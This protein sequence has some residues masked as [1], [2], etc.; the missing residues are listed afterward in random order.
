M[1]ISD[2]REMLHK[3]ALEEADD[4][5]SNNAN[6]SGDK[7]ERILQK[8]NPNE[9]VARFGGSNEKSIESNEDYANSLISRQQSEKTAGTGGNS[10]VMVQQDSL[11][12]QSSERLIQELV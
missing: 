1:C 4:G 5:R 3:K 12:D 2:R 8:I 6:D 7:L 11:K 9:N 10:G